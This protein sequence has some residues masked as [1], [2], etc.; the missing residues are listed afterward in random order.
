MFTAE[1]TEIL[2]RPDSSIDSK[3]FHCLLVL[4]PFELDVRVARIHSILL[5]Q[6][7]IYVPP[8][9]Q[10]FSTIDVDIT[11]WSVLIV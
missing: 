3:H 10:D 6:Y 9:H 8:S 1:K 4:V 2:A 11:R 7:L 5:C